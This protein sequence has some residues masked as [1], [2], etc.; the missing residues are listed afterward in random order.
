MYI[1]AIKEKKIQIHS[2]SHKFYP[3]R[4][5]SSIRIKPLKIINWQL[6]IT[7]NEE[8]SAYVI[9]IKNNE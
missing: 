7:Q 9:L 1:N 6:I 2:K 5:I 3:S 8:D 4:V